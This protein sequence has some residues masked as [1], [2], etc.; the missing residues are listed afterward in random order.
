MG[1]YKNIRQLITVINYGF[2]RDSKITHRIAD[3]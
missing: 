1:L 2:L 3:F